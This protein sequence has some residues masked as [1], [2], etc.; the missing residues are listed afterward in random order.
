[1][2]QTDHP[3]IMT[4][5]SLHNA[6]KSNQDASKSNGLTSHSISNDFELDEQTENVSPVAKRHRGVELKEFDDSK[7]LDVLNEEGIADLKEH[8]LPDTFPIAFDMPELPDNSEP[9]N[10]PILHTSVKQDS[11]SS[12]TA[13][14]GHSTPSV[15]PVTPSN[16]YTT[17]DSISSLASSTKKRRAPGSSQR[18]AKG[19][20]LF[21][22]LV[23]SKVELRGRTTYNEVSDE[24]VVDFSKAE[25]HTG[26]GSRVMDE[27]NI[28]RRVYDALNVLIA[29][30]I[31]CK[32]DK[33]IVWRGVPGMTSNERMSALE[34][35]RKLVEQVNTKRNYLQTLV[36]CELAHRKLIQRNEHNDERQNNPCKVQMPFIVVNTDKATKIY[37]E[38]KADKEKI[39]FNFDQPFEIHEDAEVLQWLGLSNVSEAECKAWLHPFLHQFVPKS[40]SQ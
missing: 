24:L 3:R 31:I 13:S 37:C 27:K 17:P 39:F 21:A 5:D 14:P 38:M 9:A 35:Q 28:R 34:T 23:C 33:C 19:L 29:L 26:A 36:T 11:P 12:I 30:G 32:E 2:S 18:L 7:F 20:S 4:S 22:R 15:P 16:T 10:N 8:I 25:Q 1:M 6:R 40:D